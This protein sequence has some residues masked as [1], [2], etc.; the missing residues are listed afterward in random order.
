[1]LILNF[2]SVQD[3]LEKAKKDFE[4][5]W[6]KNPKVSWFNAK[7]GQ[8]FISCLWN[9]KAFL[10]FCLMVCLLLSHTYINYLLDEK[11]HQHNEE[12]F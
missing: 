12:S 2:I 10:G 6:S 9:E 7:T 1:M 3:F 5:K 4:E 11:Y 8:Q